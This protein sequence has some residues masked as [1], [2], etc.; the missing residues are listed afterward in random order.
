M[1]ET[2]WT[3]G[4][5]LRVSASYWESCTIHAG[6]GL[7]IFTLI[8]DEYL[9]GDEM[10]RKLGGD[11]RGV[12]VLLDALTAMGLLLKKDGK[13]ANT[14][15]SKS[16]LVKGS[17]QYVG[18][19]I[20]HHHD[21]VPAWH[22]LSRA[23]KDG[24]PVWKE[25]GDE[26]DR[27]N[28]LMGMFNLAM[29]IAPCLAREIDIKDRHNLLDLGGGPGTYAIHFCLS[30]PGLKATIYDLLTT[31]PFA[32]KTIEHFGLSDRI[33]FAP[34]DY[35]KDEIKGIYDVVWLSHILHGLG[36][37]EC[38]LVIEKAV[39]AMEPGGMILIHDFI[40]EDTLDSPIFPALFSL[41]M[42]VN[43]EDGR[44]YSESQIKGM[45]SGVGIK[46]ISRLPFKGPNDS[47]II[48]GI[49]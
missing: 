38:R 12:S 21:L 42:L 41:N 3:V 16:M 1:N 25:S 32:S 19:M 4:Q 49:I 33:N 22:E 15:G 7:D 36:P 37:D 39:L 26:E 40:L 31:Q 46:N 47:G 45:L 2:D 5:L 10:A 23:V 6:V 48:C 17:P 29:G 18:Y 27:E 35:L 43:T 28:F 30:N 14:A 44:S 34:G 9:S 11:V 24:R 20:M 13:Y 8:G